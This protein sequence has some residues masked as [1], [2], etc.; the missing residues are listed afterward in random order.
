MRR[1][2]SLFVSVMLALGT[3][4]WIGPAPVVLAG[5]NPSTG[6]RHRRSV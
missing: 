3:L 2:A 6:A 1:L 5:S 4:V